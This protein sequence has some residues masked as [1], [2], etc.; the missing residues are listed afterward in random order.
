MCHVIY[1]ISCR[2]PLSELFADKVYAVTPSHTHTPQS[3]IVIREFISDCEERTLALHLRAV[4]MR[5]VHSCTHLPSRLPLAPLT[6]WSICGKTLTCTHHIQSVYTHTRTH[7]LRRATFYVQS[8]TARLIYGCHTYCWP[9]P[10]HTQRVRNFWWACRIRASS[11]P[12][13]T[14]TH[15]LSTLP[16][17]YHHHSRRTTKLAAQQ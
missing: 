4:V 7:T 6:R 9:M 17:P 1:L 15:T 14:H 5:F 13:P 10:N 2:N 12:P 8:A 3:H 11:T 16:L